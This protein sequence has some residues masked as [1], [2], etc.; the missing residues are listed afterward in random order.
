MSDVNLT[1]V[2][3]TADRHEYLPETIS[4]LSR[5]IERCGINIPV[6]IADNAS[7]PPI[8]PES[9]G[10]SRGSLN[11]EICRFEQRVGI[12]DSIVRSS[13]L[14]KT[15]YVWVFGDDDLIVDWGLM[16]ILEVLGNAE[17]DY[18]YMNRF[19]AP[20]DMKKMD[21]TEHVVSNPFIETEISGYEA[22]S[23]FTHHPGFITS[24]VSRVGLFENNEYVFEKMFPGFGFLGA[25]YFN[26]L[27]GNAAYISAPLLVQRKSRTLWKV[28][29]PSYW[30]ISIPTL[31]EWVD[32]QGASGA[33]A[34]V[35]EEVRGTAIR[36]A[37][38]AKASGIS[39]DESFWKES[40]RHQSFFNKSGFFIIRFL[41]PVYIAKLMVFLGSRVKQ[42]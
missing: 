5:E 24:L 17:P 7:S 22:P 13:L 6:I 38:V 36:T 18:L 42:L 9:L 25:L 27:K 23:L 41:L 11:F 28:L 31:F 26:T 12:G 15:K 4:C 34:A 8:S 35:I 39:G 32:K 40:A 33:Y 20:H 14:A 1:I 21:R 2:I 10:D 30:L 16:C 3:P 19:I 29:W 37:L